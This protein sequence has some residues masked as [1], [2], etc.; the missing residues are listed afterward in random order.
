MNACKRIIQVFLDPILGWLLSENN[1]VILTCRIAIV[2]ITPRKNSWVP[3][4]LQRPPWTRCH[5]NILGKIIWKL[6]FNVANTSFWEIFIGSETNIR[7]EPFPCQLMWH[8][9]TRWRSLVKFVGAALTF[10]PF[11]LEIWV[12]NY[13]QPRI[14]CVDLVNIGRQ[15]HSDTRKVERNCK[16]VYFRF[17]PKTSC[18]STKPGNMTVLFKILPAHRAVSKERSWLLYWLDS[19]M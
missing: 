4:R 10:S 1:S 14:L 11:E 3:L 16:K 13:F 19:G 17:G 5:L 18:F 6:I 15:W 2:G 7:L 12:V 9:V 8:L